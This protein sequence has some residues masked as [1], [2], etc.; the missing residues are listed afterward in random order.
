METDTQTTQKEIRTAPVFS[1][2]KSRSIKQM[3]MTLSI[4]AVVFA[5]PITIT[6]ILQSPGTFETRRQAAATQSYL[7]VIY[8]KSGLPFAAKYILGD[9]SG[10]KP[11]KVINTNGVTVNLAFLGDDIT[12]DLLGNKIAE[13]IEGVDIDSLSCSEGVCLVP[14][15]AMTDITEPIIANEPPVVTLQEL[16]G[17]MALLG[18][19]ELFQIKLTIQDTNGPQGDYIEEITYEKPDW[20]Q[21]TPMI[22][23]G[24]GYDN[25][26]TIVR[27]LSGIP[28]GE[29]GEETVTI[30]ITD[31][32]GETSSDSFT[33]DV[34]EQNA[35]PTITPPTTEKSY[36]FETGCTERTET[37]HT[38]SFDAEA[39]DTNEDS[40]TFLVRNVTPSGLNIHLEGN[41]SEKISFTTLKS[42]APQTYSLD[43]IAKEVGTD[44]LL[45]SEPLKLTFLTKTKDIKCPEQS[46]PV[47]VISV[48]PPAGHP[49][50][51]ILL[52]AEGSYDPD[53]QIQSYKWTFGDGQSQTHNYPINFEHTYIEVG[54]YNLVLEVTDDDGLSSSNSTTIQVGENNAPVVLLTKPNTGTYSGSQTNPNN[55]I[56]WLVKDIEND[57][58]IGYEISLHTANEGQECSYNTLT[59]SRKFILARGN[60]SYEAGGKKYF[61]TS[62]SW[63]TG[64]HLAGEVP[65]GFYC[66]KATISD[67]TYGQITTDYSD[68]SIKIV[69]AEHAPYIVTDS[70][71]EATKGT[72]Y[73]TQILAADEDNDNLNFNM[74][75]GPNWLNVDDNGRLHGIPSESGP[76]T[77]IIAVSDGKAER[78]KSYTLNVK[79][80]EGQV[81]PAAT[82]ETNIEIF[83]GTDGRILWALEN[84]QDV[85]SLNIEYSE[86]GQEWTA[87]ATN[88]ARDITEYEWDVTELADGKYL[89]RILYFDKNGDKLGASNIQEINVSNPKQT[90]ESSPVIFNLK[91]V[92]NAT[93]Y[94]LTPILSANFVA[95]KE[96]TVQ[97]DSIQVY[98]DE[99]LITD[100][101]GFTSFEGGFTYIPRENLSEGKHTIKVN[102]SDSMDKA[103]EKEWYFDVKEEDKE[104][105]IIAEKADQEQSLT[106]YII[107]IVTIIFIGGSTVVA[108]FVVHKLQ[109]EKMLKETFAPKV[110]AIDHKQYESEEKVFRKAR[111][112]LEKEG[113]KSPIAQ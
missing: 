89:V 51:T 66:V 82:I 45:E 32:F 30:S 63:N 29:E 94:D 99:N 22:Y 5:I 41:R 97:E 47:A 40:F 10:S 1:T 96:G 42:D 83:V 8:E 79:A 26:E 9:S 23:Q 61:P 98:L 54:I 87:L 62:I 109:E 7:G 84:A 74:V 57:T 44:E 16:S 76:F 14:S 67:N 108:Y 112:V 17:D 24:Q 86:D 101:S 69:N 106:R 113:S 20:L 55:T 103:A 80:T 25:S 27:L 4:L 11:R 56:S 46:P 52:N 93:I 65:D 58:P 31:F 53:G 33:F 19:E 92:E 111:A 59:S 102:F 48:S 95:S 73:S 39:I 2:P 70:I 105:E 75:L 81:L 90:T 71:P 72:S 18:M 12:T 38:F 85:A 43:L 6:S 104:E 91:P 88:I 68:N 49:P 107:A 28:D 21:I 78:S 34:K 100:K 37:K 64:V 13:R 77:V 35:A 3:I 50:L 36:T 60:M 15:L 110:S